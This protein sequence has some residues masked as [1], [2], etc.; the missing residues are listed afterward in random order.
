MTYT[1][2][3]GMTPYELGV[4]IREFIRIHEYT[5]KEVAAQLGMSESYFSLLVNGQVSLSREV[6]KRMESVFGID[7]R[8]LYTRQAVHQYNT[9]SDI[10]APRGTAL[11]ARAEQRKD[12][13]H[14]KYSQH[15]PEAASVT[16]QEAGQEKLQPASTAFSIEE[17]FPEQSNLGAALPS[18]MAPAPVKA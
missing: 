11:G 16:E 14:G 17:F 1:Q 13:Y 3:E 5:A 9:A 4:Y 18:A 12:T 6:A 2:P 10:R 15:Q 8:M 7:G